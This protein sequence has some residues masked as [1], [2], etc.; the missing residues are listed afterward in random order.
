M[1]IMFFPAFDYSTAGRK[2]NA[3]NKPM[4]GYMIDVL[5]RYYYVLLTS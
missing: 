3:K 4:I 1:H 5:V 2:K